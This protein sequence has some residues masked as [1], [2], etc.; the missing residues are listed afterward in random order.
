MW[1]EN[2]GIDCLVQPPRLRRR[3]QQRVQEIAQQ[4]LTSFLPKYLLEA[5][6][7]ERVEVFG[8]HAARCLLIKLPLV[9]DGAI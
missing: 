4:R 6:V 5:K 9:P 7:G 2:E 3:R 1:F 8:F